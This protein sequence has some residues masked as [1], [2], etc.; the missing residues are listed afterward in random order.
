MEQ[1][2]QNNPFKKCTYTR[3]K[4]RSF[5]SSLESYQHGA[6]KESLLLRWNKRL[7]MMSV[8]WHLTKVFSSE[9]IKSLRTKVFRYLKEHGIVAVA[10]IELT[11]GKDGR[12]NNTVHFHFLTDDQRSIK[13][14][15][16]LFNT[17]CEQQGLVRRKDFWISCQTLPDADRY[18]DYF[19]KRNCDDVILF[20]KGTG[21]QKFYQIGKWFKGGKGKIW[22]EIRAYM[23]GRDWNRWQRLVRVLGTRTVNGTHFYTPH[24]RNQDTIDWKW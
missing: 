8:I 19:T 24:H 20:S 16:Q 21:L 7:P 1:L 13:E 9:E 12:P 23:R 17:A 4:S 5:T 2:Y 3:Y 18:F 14:I 15:R 6:S 10:S 11:C 22:K